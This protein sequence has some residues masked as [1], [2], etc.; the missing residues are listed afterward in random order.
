LRLRK[1]PKGKELHHKCENKACVN[2]EHLELLTFKEHRGRHTRY[3]LSP[4]EHLQVK[5]WV[6][7]G[8]KTMVEV[9]ELMGLSY[10]A[11]YR[12]AWANK[13]YKEEIFS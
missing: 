3:L 4:A 13:R 7:T 12:L 2:P 5:K 9:A 8:E 1:V 11:V 10:G 6:R